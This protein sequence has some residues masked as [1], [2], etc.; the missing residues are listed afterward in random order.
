M[1]EEDHI[2][3]AVMPAFLRVL[4]VEPHPGDRGEAQLGILG[5]Q[6]VG[7]VGGVAIQLC[8]AIVQSGQQQNVDDILLPRNRIVVEDCGDI[9]VVLHRHAVAAVLAHEALHLRE[10]H[11]VVE[12]HH[13]SVGVG[14]DGG[15][16]GF[17]EQVGLGVG[18]QS[19]SIRYSQIF[20]SGIPSFR[21]DATSA[22]VNQS[23]SHRS[24]ISSSDLPSSARLIAASFGVTVIIF[25]Y[26]LG[27]ISSFI[28]GV[29]VQPVNIPSFIE[30]EFRQI[31][32]GR[33]L[34][35]VGA[36]PPSPLLTGPGLILLVDVGL[37]I[38]VE[39]PVS[40]PVVFIPLLVVSVAEHRLSRPAQPRHLPKGLVPELP[41]FGV[42]G[43]LDDLHTGRRRQYA[44]IF[45]D[46]IPDS[47]VLLPL[48]LCRLQR[49]LQ[50]L[51][52][53]LQG[54]LGLDQG[55]DILA[56]P[57]A[58]E[59]PVDLRLCLL[60]DRRGPARQ[61][62]QSP[63]MLEGRPHQVSRQLLVQV[64]VEVLVR[65]LFL[66]DRAIELGQDIPMRV[67]ASVG[68]LEV[69][70]LLQGVEG[71]ED[72]RRQGAVVGRRRMGQLMAQSP[73]HGP[74]G[75]H[76]VAVEGQNA[77]LDAGVGLGKE[78]LRIIDHPNLLDTVALGED[79][80]YPLRS[81][82]QLPA[83]RGLPG[84]LNRLL[85]TLTPLSGFPGCLPLFLTEGKLL[86]TCVALSVCL[87]ERL[88]K[89]LDFRVRSVLVAGHLP[90]S[91]PELVQAHPTLSFHA[92][93]HRAC[94]LQI[95]LISQSHVRLAGLRESVPIGLGEILVAYQRLPITADLAHGLC[96]DLTGPVP[97]PFG[98][99]DGLAAQGEAILCGRGLSS[100]DFRCRD[101]D[102]GFRLGRL[103]NLCLLELGRHLCRLLLLDL[104]SAPVDGI[105]LLIGDLFHRELDPR[106]LRE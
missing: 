93:I 79:R 28:M 11:G 10:L 98:I 65:L 13:L 31:I 26:L 5:G 101:I 77:I 6:V 82:L 22:L 52:Q 27:E 80:L 56:L 37:H 18:L 25:S 69:A 44:A 54:R 60:Q 40:P 96:H 55:T 43:I 103:G 66:P 88:E 91:A 53:G 4:R 61:A 29:Q 105:Q 20:S 71:G 39:C 95:L 59:E 68:V 74:G 15:T 51:T 67:N 62:V 81:A 2:R 35:L 86:Y 97:S 49:F 32:G 23:A 42:G 84:L 85:Q 92:S 45:R 14:L 78:S 73:V 17:G 30:G 50:A 87:L 100:G 46:G 12:V 7:S 47:T 83:S 36:F 102:G 19:S 63:L 1:D 99:R 21:Q 48:P 16:Q 33:I 72:V 9:A 64:V 104:G 76:L 8:A 3:L 89:R 90:D 41:I 94:V 38:G 58:G 75:V 24:S 106:E 34:I 70:A 57:E